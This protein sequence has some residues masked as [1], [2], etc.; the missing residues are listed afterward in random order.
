M[1]EEIDL[2]THRALVTGAGQSLGR[3]IAVSLGAA[4]AEVVVND[5]L[6]ERAESV[7]EEIRAAG[8]RAISS[9]FDVTDPAMV[10]AAVDRVNGIDIL[11]NNAGDAGGPDVAG[12]FD[13][14]LLVDANPAK[15]DP[16]RAIFYGVMVCTNACLPAMIERRFGRIVTVIS[17]AARAGDALPDA[18]H[19]GANEG[20]AGFTRSIATENG[21]YGITANI[22]SV[23]TMLGDSQAG[24]ASDA[25]SELGR[26]M[27]R[28]L[29]EPLGVASLVT[30]LVSPL[31]SWLTGQTIPVNGGYT[32]GALTAFS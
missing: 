16:Y 25:K 14:N 29:G 21:C 15:W 32:T 8:G 26:Y 19:A 11:V 13:L 22:V 18:V 2:R 27:T 7:A 10:R 1:A 5:L 20:A 31:A 4:G 30:Y 24:T 28:R 23:A 12:S 6:P 3:G 9:P 17:D